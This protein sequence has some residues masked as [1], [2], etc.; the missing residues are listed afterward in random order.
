MRN[1]RG[2]ATRFCYGESTSEC[3]CSRARKNLTVEEVCARSGSGR[4]AQLLVRGIVERNKAF[5]CRALIPL[6]RGTAMERLNP[7]A[8]G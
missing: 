5:C 1:V 8:R 7:R 2:P 6:S 3:A 4:L